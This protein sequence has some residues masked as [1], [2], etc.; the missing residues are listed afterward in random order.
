M[1]QHLHG[2]LNAHQSLIIQLKQKVS[3]LEM[4]L[5]KKVCKL[6]ILVYYKIY[7][8]IIYQIKQIFIYIL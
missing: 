4:D 3:T 1:I 2:E 8:F 5:A 7:I 6:L